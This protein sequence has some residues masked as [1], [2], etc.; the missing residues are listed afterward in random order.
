MSG[1]ADQSV[2]RAANGTQPAG[3][4]YYLEGSSHDSREGEAFKVW[5]ERVELKVRR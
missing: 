1:V 5:R 2:P 4:L 3:A